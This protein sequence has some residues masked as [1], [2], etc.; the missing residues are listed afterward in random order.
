MLQCGRCSVTATASKLC[1]GGCGWAAAHRLWDSSRWFSGQLVN[2]LWIVLLGWFSIAMPAPHDRVTSLQEALLQLATDAMNQDFRVVDADQTLR[3][4]ADLH[5]L[6]NH[7]TV[8]FAASDGRYRGMV[9][10]DQLRLVERSQWES[11]T[12]H[13]ILRP[14]AKFTVAESNPLSR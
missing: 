6:E 9:S 13:S 12:L 1:T 8:Y 5:L 11:Q 10:I 7:Y 3:Q 14:L 4:F 2:G